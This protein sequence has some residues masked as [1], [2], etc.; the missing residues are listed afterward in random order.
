VV[1]P[2][3]PVN[4]DELIK[5]LESQLVPVTLY[6]PIALY[7]VNRR[8]LLYPEV[9]QEGKLW[10][11]RRPL[12]PK[13]HYEF[14]N[15]RIE[16]HYAQGTF[17]D[18]PTNSIPSLTQDLEWDDTIVGSIIAKALKYLGVNMQSADLFQFGEHRD[19]SGS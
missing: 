4:E 11:L 6:D 2:L 12:K 13:Y 18:P 16:T 19:K 15:D 8:M 1:R 9:P 10:Y 3:I 5:R 7:N 17:L 14:L